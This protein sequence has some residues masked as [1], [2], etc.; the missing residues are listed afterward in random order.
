MPVMVTEAINLEEELTNM[1]ATLERLSKKSKEKDAQIKRQ[2][3]QI[4]SLKKKLE[5][6]S[7][8]ALNKGSSDEDPDEE[9]N[10]NKQS[11]DER[12][13]K[14]DS[15]LNQYRLSKFKTC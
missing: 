7:F 12:N 4:A 1:T 15:T 10:H 2:N 5:N 14:N 9:S 3:K 11:N 6:R 8:E 13:P